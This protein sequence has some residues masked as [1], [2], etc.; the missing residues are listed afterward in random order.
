MFVNIIL[1][2]NPSQ[3]F[4]NA[5]LERYPAALS[6]I[7]LGGMAF[8]AFLLLL[9]VIFNRKRKSPFAAESDADLPDEVRKRLGSRSANRALWIFRF[10]FVACA[11]AIFGF[12][13]YWAMYAAQKDP[14]FQV[15]SKRDI[16][17]K[18]AGVSNLRGWILDR[19]GDLNTAFAFWR[20][21]K[22]KDEKGRE[23]EKLVREMPMDREMAHLLGTNFGTLGLE[24]SLFKHKTDD[25]T[26]EAIDV[27]AQTQPKKDE[28]KDVRL[29]LDRD[30]QKF[31]YEQLKDK[32]GA[33]VVLNPQNGEVLAIASNPT[34]SLSEAKTLD[35]YRALEE[36]IKDKP[37]ISRAMGEYYVPGSTFK[38]F[39]MMAA[40]RAGRQNE[41]LTSSGGGYVPYKNSRAITDANGGCE[42]PYGCAPLDIGQAFEA[43][44]NQFFSQMAVVLERNRL[45]ETAQLLGIDAVE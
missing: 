11:L 9:F 15:L 40:F 2:F 22:T 19:S 13:T 37:L 34:F 36:N 29:T 25:P 27:V 28:A 3:F 39:T 44:S 21:E 1:Q 12:H 17:V 30:L 20:I 24:S 6:L 41:I 10:V 33:I 4:G 45:R 26:P 32:R 7:Y 35:Q 43:S 31:A 42:P 38:T 14:R 5:P 18:R 23:D 16:R 8:V